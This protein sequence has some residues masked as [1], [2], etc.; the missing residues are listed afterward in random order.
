MV[1]YLPQPTENPT[2]YADSIFDQIEVMGRRDVIRYKINN[3]KLQLQPEKSGLVEKVV[4]RTTET[5]GTQNYFPLYASQ[6]E[7]P[8]L[9]EGLT[10][11]DGR[12]VEDP[13]LAGGTVY[14][15]KVD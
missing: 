12:I 7:K 11:S 9:F 14:P 1:A 15:V 4:L 13:T 6:D 5:D 3:T 10:L 8:W 2:A